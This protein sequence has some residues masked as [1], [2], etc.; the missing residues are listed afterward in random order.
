MDQTRAN[1]KYSTEHE[2]I[3]V[4]GDV[5]TIGITPYAQEALGDMVYVELPDVGATFSVGEHFAVAESVKAASEI[6]APIS[7][8]V[9]EVNEDLPD[10]PEALN[11]SPFDDGWIAKFKIE[12]V[13]ELET[14][15]TASDYEVY[16][17]GLI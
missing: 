1:L 13:K 10:A 16:I 17:E 9:V 3:L 12:D 5:A 2:W 6:Y 4:E 7:G 11:Y 15:M 14:L 8:E